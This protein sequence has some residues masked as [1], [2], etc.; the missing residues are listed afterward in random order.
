MASGRTRRKPRYGGSIRNCNVTPLEYK[1][2]EQTGMIRVKETPA[3]G[4]YFRQWAWGYHRSINFSEV[5]GAKEVFQIKDDFDAPPSSRLLDTWHGVI[6]VEN[7][8]DRYVITCQ[9]Y[10][11]KRRLVHEFDLY[12][13]HTASRNAKTLVVRKPRKEFVAYEGGNK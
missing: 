9:D 6:A 10:G 4:L 2:Y 3:E 11:Q 1:E 8:P 13:Y 5:L 7:Y 12:G